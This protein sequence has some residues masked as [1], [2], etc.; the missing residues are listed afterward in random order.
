LTTAIAHPCLGLEPTFHSARMGQ[1]QVATD[2]FVV[3]AVAVV[4]VAACVVVVAVAVVST[5][6]GTTA[7]L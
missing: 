2:S 3:V 1:S 6:A 5:A 4:V 7:L